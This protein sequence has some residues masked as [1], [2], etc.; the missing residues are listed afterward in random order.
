MMRSRMNAGKKGMKAV[1][2][3]HQQQEQRIQQQQQQEQRQ[4]RQQ[5]LRQQPT[6]VELPLPAAAPVEPPVVEEPVRKVPQVA[7]SAVVTSNVGSPALSVASI[8]A[9]DVPAEQVIAPS[10]PKPA[11]EASSMPNG[12][13]G[14]AGTR[15]KGKSRQALLIEDTSKFSTNIQEYANSTRWTI[16][17]KNKALEAFG[18]FGRDFLRVATHVGSK[19]VAN[20]EEFYNLYK[21]KL[22]L[23]VI[24]ADVEARKNRTHVGGS[25]SPSGNV[26]ND[27]GAKKKKKKEKSGQKLVFGR[28]ESAMDVDS[29]DSSVKME[30]AENQLNQQQQMSQQ[31]TTEIHHHQ[32]VITRERRRRMSLSSMNEQEPVGAKAAAA[33][34]LN[35]PIW[36]D[37][38]EIEFRKGLRAHGCN[39]DEISKLVLSKSCAQ[40]RA[41]Y[42]GNRAEFD[43]ILLEA[44]QKP[45]AYYDQQT[46]Y[47]ANSE[48]YVPQPYFAHAVYPMYPQP[49]QPVFNSMHG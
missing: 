19:T 41:H 35:S 6:E 3:Q 32:E 37:H 43:K 2:L 5:L 23:D 18:N 15:S 9:K 7:T 24:T 31:G 46:D 44:G 40:S 10:I 42:S 21:R 48:Q 30:M 22:N 14:V 1:Q 27:A 13:S 34:S 28:D 29:T 33:P 38:E 49:V 11:A 16:D 26:S 45:E 39:F 36:S 20:C 17:E 47:R 8:P 12:I 25:E 4:Q